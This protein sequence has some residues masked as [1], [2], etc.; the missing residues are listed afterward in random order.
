MH[1]EVGKHREEALGPACGVRE[2][3]LDEMTSE[4]GAERGQGIS[5]MMTAEGMKRTPGSKH[6]KTGMSPVCARGVGPESGRSRG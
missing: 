2:D 5:Q 6:T 3:A 4:L 1:G